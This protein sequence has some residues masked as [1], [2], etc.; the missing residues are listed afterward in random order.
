MAHPLSRPRGFHA[1]G[2]VVEL[3]VQRGEQ[4]VASRGIAGFGALD[5]GGDLLGIS[6]GLVSSITSA[7]R[8]AW[9]RP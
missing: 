9:Q 8:G 3:V 6:G 4:R 1:A 2:Q 5:H 7:T